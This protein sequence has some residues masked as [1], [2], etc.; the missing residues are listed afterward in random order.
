MVDS[1]GNHVGDVEGDVWVDTSTTH[2]KQ[3]TPDVF[4]IREVY[5]PC[6]CDVKIG[7]IEKKL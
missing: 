1:V 7:T 5:A 3:L 6:G 2:Y 4:E